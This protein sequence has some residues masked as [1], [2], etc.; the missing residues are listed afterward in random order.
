MMQTLPIWTIVAILFA[1]WMAD[2]VAQTDQMA[3]NKST[4]MRWLISHVAAYGAFVA[5][6][7]IVLLGKLPLIWLLVNVL[8]HGC[9][10]FV[11][12]RITSRLYR[13]GE[14]HWFFVVIGF[15]QFLHTSMLL[16]TAVYLF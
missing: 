10:D 16:V 11:T 8:L 1:H 7:L 15:D 14:T 13:A 2:F 9:V 5:V 12:S 3:K 4:S 6:M